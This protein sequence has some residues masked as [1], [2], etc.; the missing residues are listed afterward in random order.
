MEMQGGVI[1]ATG[2]IEASEKIKN[3]LIEGGYDVLDVCKSGNEVIMKSIQYSP[4]L[5]ILS[6]KLPDTTVM[7]I[8]DSLVGTCDFLVLASEPYLSIVSENMDVYYLPNPFSKSILLNSVNM[9][10][11]SR[12]KMAKL[13][14]KVE[15]LENKMEE[16]K[17]IEKAKALLIKNKK[18]TEEEAFRIIQ[19]RSM[20]SGK[21]M[22]D[23]AKEI[24]ALY[25]NQ[26]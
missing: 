22:I 25:I 26:K 19:K 18:I 9:I 10:F 6:Y 5:V 8:Y 13:Q 4:E 24:L 21:K 7:E 16:R 11:Q 2:K 3:I 15:N 23:I 1:V 17:V 14:K 12:K 20:N